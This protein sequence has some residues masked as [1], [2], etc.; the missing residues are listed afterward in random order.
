MKKEKSKNLIV[1]VGNGFDL[2]HGL[3]TGFGHFADYYI[4]TIID[5][6]LF[7]AQKKEV[8][9]YLEKKL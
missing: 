1:I 7:E 9:S 6:E 5:N 2:A 3:K 4:E 8:L